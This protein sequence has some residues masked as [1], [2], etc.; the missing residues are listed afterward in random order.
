MAKSPQPRR[1]GRPHKTD[2]AVHSVP[3]ALLQPKAV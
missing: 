2:A 1:R 3:E